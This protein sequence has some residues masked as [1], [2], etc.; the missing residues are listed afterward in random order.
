MKVLVHIMCMLT[1][2][3]IANDYFCINKNYHM[4]ITSLV[5][6]I[7][8]VAA[9]LTLAIAFLLKLHKS[10]LMTFFQSFCGVLF[11]FS[12]WVKAIDPMGTAFKMEQYFGEFESV[13][14]Q[15]WFSFIAPVFPMLSNVSILFLV[16]MIVYEVV[17]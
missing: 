13:F 7:G 6:N 12:G 8:I 4:S 11:I 15:T 5:L 10:Y 2:F 9:I 14:S 3:L 1:F 16:S 17:L